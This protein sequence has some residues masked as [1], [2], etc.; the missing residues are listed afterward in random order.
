MML[1]GWALEQDTLE[2]DI[3]QNNQ[4]N[5]QDTQSS[6]QTRP[7]KFATGRLAVPDVRSSDRLRR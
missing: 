1:L 3:G 2:Q 5:N 6:E 7:A 4:D